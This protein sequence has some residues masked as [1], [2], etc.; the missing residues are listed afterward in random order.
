MKVYTTP[1][2]SRPRSRARS[3]CPLG[4]QGF[5]QALAGKLSLDL[6][7]LHFLFLPAAATVLKVN[8]AIDAK[9]RVSFRPEDFRV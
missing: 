6:P 5:K 1:S 2:I 4:Q 3:F 7:Q 9:Q 8:E